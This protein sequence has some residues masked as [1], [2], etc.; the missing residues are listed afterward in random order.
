MGRGVG[1]GDGEEVKGGGRVR[2]GELG[3]EE[4]VVVGSR[5][6]DRISGPHNS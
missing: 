1:Q 6:V 3:E 5:A 2:G 4:L